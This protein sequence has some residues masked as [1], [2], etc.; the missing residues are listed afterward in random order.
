MCLYILK[1]SYII[2]YNT[3][4][5]N[6]V[7]PEFKVSERMV[8][9]RVGDPLQLNCTPDAHSSSGE[10]V[11]Y[12]DLEDSRSPT[13]I[14]QLSYR[15]LKNGVEVMASDLDSGSSGLLNV[16][17]AVNMTDSGMYS[18]V[19]EDAVFEKRALIFN[20][21]KRKRGIVQ[22]PVF[23][24]FEGVALSLLGSPILSSAV[25]FSVVVGGEHWR[26]WN[27]L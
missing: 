13:G 24:V 2:S 6:T 12:Y 1:T 15:L 22:A 14:T 7:P 4:Y 9:V 18:C 21:A 25:N 26:H 16:T 10:N 8:Y 17:E 5:I 23:E 11:P 20:L 3:C 27:H 19:V